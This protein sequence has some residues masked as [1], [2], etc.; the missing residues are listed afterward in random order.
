M[1]QFGG[2]HDAC[3]RQALLATET[4]VADD[5]A[6]A[7]PGHL[8]TSALLFFQSQNRSLSA[9]EI[10]AA[11]VTAFHLRPTPD[12]CD[13]IISFAGLSLDP[14][15]CRLAVQ[16]VGGPLTG[17]PNSGVWLPNQRR[18]DPDLELVAQRLEWR[19]LS[20]ALGSRVRYG[21]SAL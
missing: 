14:A 15:G 11:A 17:P 16:F 4:F 18:T 1:A 3:L 6:M 21:P 7:C 20:A 5:G 10:R 2:F 9:I 13:S 19:G 12:S 8:D